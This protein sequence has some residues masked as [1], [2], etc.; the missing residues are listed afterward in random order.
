MTKENNEKK[1]SLAL[2]HEHCFRIAWVTQ[3]SFPFSSN[4]IGMNLQYRTYSSECPLPY[5][6]LTF[7]GMR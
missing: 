6:L 7:F 5:L 2:R 1:G 4:L 3:I